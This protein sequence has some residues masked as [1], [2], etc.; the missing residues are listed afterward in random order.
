MSAALPGTVERTLAAGVSAIDAVEP[1]RVLAG[2]G[3]WRPGRLVQLLRA[4]RRHGRS[5]AVV[6]AGG[7]PS[8]LAVMD[9]DGPVTYPDLDAMADACAANAATGASWPRRSGR[10]GLGST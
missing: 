5:L 2:A 3:L 9:G 10:P 1:M 6:L 7:P 4:G 8:G